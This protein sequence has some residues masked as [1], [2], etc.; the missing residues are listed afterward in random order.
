VKRAA[1]PPPNRERAV[2]SL[3]FAR[4]VYALNWYNIGAVLPLIGKDLGA[5]TPELGIVVSSFL[6]GAAVFQIVAGFATLRWGNRSV[7][8]FALFLMGSFA[9][10]SA[11]SPNWEVLALL[12]FGTGA[13]AAFF[14]APALGLVASF[15]PPGRQ[16]PIIGLYNSGFA[17]GSGIGL[18]GGALV[19]AL[20][21]WSAAL[22][23]GGI[24]LLGAGVISPVLV[25]SQ[26]ATRRRRSWRA[27]WDVALPT[28]RSRSLWAL[29]LAT[30]GLWGAFTVGAQYF[31]QYAATVHGSWSIAI[32]AGIPTLM[33]VF[34]IPGGPIGGLL[35]ERA[36]EMRRVLW[37]WGA[38]A[39]VLFILVPYLG[40]PE[41]FV[42]FAFLGFAE[43]VV[44]AVLYLLP[45]TFPETHGE[46]YALGLA[47]LNA[48]QLVLGS[49]IALAFALIADAYGYTAAWWFTGA[50]AL[51]LLPMVVWVVGHRGSV[52]RPAVPGP[53]TGR[54]VPLPQ[55]RE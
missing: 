18:F 32:A 37:V 2:A 22:L 35:G 24:V 43:G 31:I 11:F 27:M 13:G 5:T 45:S 12:R 29:S 46:S 48:I 14:F 47:L 38:A 34:E 6:I 1:E 16:G 50:I 41:L 51:V 21:G 33:I 30:A 55:Q 19:G 49:A 52:L 44:F 54:A 20:Y 36:A 10:A 9:T 25:P 53:A 26:P 3:V 23:V 7:S 39:G 42:L 8:I 17:I 4:I 15:Y 40:Y 28:L